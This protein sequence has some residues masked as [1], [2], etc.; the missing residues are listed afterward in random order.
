[1]RRNKERERERDEK[2]EMEGQEERSRC[3]TLVALCTANR[4]LPS[5]L[6]SHCHARPHVKAPH[7]CSRACL[8][9]LMSY[10]RP[11]LAMPS[12]LQRTSSHRQKIDKNGTGRSAAP[13]LLLRWRGNGVAIVAT[14]EKNW[15]FGGRGPA[16]HVLNTFHSHFLHKT[17]LLPPLSHQP[18]PGPALTC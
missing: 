11:L 14:Q 12:P 13:V 3:K 8:M 18:A 16:M 4:L 1:M 6:R 10:P 7:T 2:K 15:R 5:T 17:L 9:V